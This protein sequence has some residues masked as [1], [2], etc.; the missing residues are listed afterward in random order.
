MGTMIVTIDGPAG[1]GKSTV[2]RRLATR[3]G[4]A[5]LDTG[6]MYRAVTLAALRRGVELQDP[7][8]VAELARTV[9]IELDAGRVWLDGDE[10]TEAIRNPEITDLIRYVSQPPE[11]RRELVRRQREWVGSRDVVT[12]GRDQ[13]TVAFPQARC[14]IFLTA[15]PEV[16]AHRRWCELVAK[17]KDIS[18]AQVLQ[19]Q[20]ERDHNDSQRSEGP[21]RKADDAIEVLT[22]GLELDEV[23]ERLAAI[24]HERVPGAEDAPMDRNSSPFDSHRTP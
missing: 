21:L 3:L 12:E 24:V 17:G 15:S 5:F 9:T 7:S 8:A 6:A 19:M 22:D 23:V 13:G 4:F 11:V 16:R 18:E 10:V 14:K 1:A 20:I 2:A